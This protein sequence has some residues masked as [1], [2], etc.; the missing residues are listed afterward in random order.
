MQGDK[1]QIDHILL[2]KGLRVSGA[3]IDHSEDISASFD[4]FPVVV[5]IALAGEPSSDGSSDAGLDYGF[6]SSATRRH[7][8]HGHSCGTHSIT[9]AVVLTAVCFAMR[10]LC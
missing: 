3:W 1:L 9:T 5:D 8:T 7:G 4:H 6:D 10:L 2:S